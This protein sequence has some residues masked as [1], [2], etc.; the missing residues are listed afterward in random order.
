MMVNK[1]GNFQQYR[2]RETQDP[3]WMRIILISISVIF[4]ILLLFLPLI[5]VF[6]EAF[7][8]GWEVY[9]EAIIDQ[10]TLSAIKLTTIIVAV[11]VPLN[12]IFGICAAWCISKFEFYG[13][14]LLV[15]LIDLPF[16][17]SPI[18]SG[19]IFVLI[20][21]SHTI[22]GNFLSLYNIKIIFALP[23]LIIATIF[24]T[25]PFIVKELVPLMQSQGSE[26]EEAAILLGASPLR[27]FY[28]IT[29]PKIK[30][31]L[32][33]GVLL[34]SAR[35]MGEFGAVSVVS[36]HIRGVTNTVPLHVEILYNEY[37]FI[38]ASAVA[39]I[40]TLISLVTLI[41][42]ALVEWVHERKK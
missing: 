13:K 32:I 11:V 5:S 39:S 19:L 33:Y 10:D 28:Y 30:W 20:F 9:K 7:S 17:V 8:Q 23:G 38:G 24:V 21:G 41:T 15:T 37:N 42:K 18:I 6:I 40:L 36:G 22:I 3:F 2:Q 29:L 4:L 1:F 27:V 12:L 34:C 16:S 35:A 26:E 31:G 14:S 25:F